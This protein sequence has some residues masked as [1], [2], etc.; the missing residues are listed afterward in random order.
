[1]IIGNYDIGIGQVR[2]VSRTPCH[3]P[4]TCE[5]INRSKTA[6]LVFDFS[7]IVIP[8]GGAKTD[9]FTAG[10]GNRRINKHHAPNLEDTDQ[11]QE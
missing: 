6:V 3:T 7:G 10:I 8:N 9:G 11:D 4:D 1:M 5:L 2:E